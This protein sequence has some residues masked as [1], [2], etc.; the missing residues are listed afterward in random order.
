MQ[1]V[2]S[3]GGVELCLG[4]LE[5]KQYIKNREPLLMLD[6]ADIKVGEF[7]KA[8][9][10]LNADEWYFAC[11]YPGEPMMPGV[12]QLE[13]LGQAGT[14]LMNALPGNKG[15]LA[16]LSR[17]ANAA[18]YKKVLPLTALVAEVKLKSFRRGLAKLSGEIS[19]D[20]ALVCSADFMLVYPDEMNI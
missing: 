17:Y 11:H 15:K 10:Y 20:G 9:K 12:L 18:F 8:Y 3:G 19:V 6:S 14:L 16:I 5:I 4:K 7:V 2:F 1:N 13:L